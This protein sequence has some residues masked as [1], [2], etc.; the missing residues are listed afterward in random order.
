MSITTPNANMAEP[1]H[2][3][4]GTD[5]IHMGVPDGELISLSAIEA[6]RLSERLLKAAVLLQGRSAS[7][8]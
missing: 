3:T 1:I 8:R 6:L 4:V 2:L 5:C 7:S